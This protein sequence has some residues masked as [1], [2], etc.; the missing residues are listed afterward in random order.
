MDLSSSRILT[1]SSLSNAIIIPAIRNPS[2]LNKNLIN[3]LQIGD[4]SFQKLRTITTTPVIKSETNSQNPKPTVLIMN[5]H[6]TIKS[7]PQQTITVNRLLLS[8]TNNPTIINGQNTI[9]LATFV[10]SLLQPTQNSISKLLETP[11]NVVQQPSLRP[12]KYFQF[13]F[14]FKTFSLFSYSNNE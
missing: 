13:L 8:N 12:S 11:I 3:P 9:N 7:E 1:S 2:S 10:N 6:P 14:S 5:H 4:A